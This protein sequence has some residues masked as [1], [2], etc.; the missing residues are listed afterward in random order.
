[1]NVKISEISESKQ[2]FCSVKPMFALS[3]SKFRYLSNSSSA[4]IA[5]FFDLSSVSFIHITDTSKLR[6]SC[7][8]NVTLSRGNEL[9]SKKLKMLKFD[10]NP[11]KIGYN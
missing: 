4:V 9:L 8:A 1:M 5:I 2:T 7:I 3:V 6:K 11:N 10:V